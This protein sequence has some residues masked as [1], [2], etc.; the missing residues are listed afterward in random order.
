VDSVA[1]RPSL[2]ERLKRVESLRDEPDLASVRDGLKKALTDS[3][4]LVAS[5]A[6]RIISELELSG[7]EADLLKAWGRFLVD[8]VKSDKGCRA[9]S[10][11]VEALG[12]TGFDDVDFWLAGMSY[13]QVE[14]LWPQ[15]EDTA[16]E[17]RG[18]CAFGLARSRMLGPVKKLTALVDLLHSS[19]E[20]D[21]IHA[22]RAVVDTASDS[23]IPLLKSKLLEGDVA[24]VQGACFSGL[25]GLAPAE[26]LPLVVS[27]LRHKADDV[28]AEACAALGECGLPSAVDALIASAKKSQSTERLETILQSLGL[29]RSTTAVDF[30]VTRVQADGGDALTAFHALRPA[31]VHPEIRMRLLDAAKDSS[32]ARLIAAAKV[33]RG[34]PGE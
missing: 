22:V 13:K 29:S 34:H 5:A 2:D 14:P 23:A 31:C 28:H 24:G 18:G 30:L 4:N 10:A 33:L 6:A 26:F 9:K 12:R 32:Q 27:Y 15:P 8:P 16:V 17:V 19:S 3:S 7:F 1:S 20:A 11:I 21:R 25:L